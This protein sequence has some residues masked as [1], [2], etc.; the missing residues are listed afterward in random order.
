MHTHAHPHP[1]DSPSALGRLGVVFAI[2]VVFMVVEWLVGLW[3]GSLALISDAGHMLTDSTALALSFCA[4]WLS[5]RPPNPRQSFGY[6]R[7]EILAALLNAAFLLVLAV[8]ILKE[9]FERLGSPREIPGVP[10]LLVA[11]AGLVVN[12]VAAFLLARDAKGNLNIHG[13]FLHVLFDA[14]GSVAAIV[15]GLAIV[16]FGFYLA[17]S[18]VAFLLATLIVIGSWRLLWQSIHVLMEGT[19]RHLNLEALRARIL[20][21]EQVRDICDLHV[22]CLTPTIT[23][24]SAH[25]VTHTWDERGRTLDELTQILRLEFQIDHV[26]LQ[27]EAERSTLCPNQSRLAH[28]PHEIHT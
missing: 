22:W 15:A 23:H 19:P 24:A 1:H 4:S 8:F 13:A 14:L 25:I 10:M 28:R 9:A 12:L 11:C 17:D 20:E 3:T 7:A 6:V 2:T 21:H 27:L 5:R 16:F 18:L 26:T